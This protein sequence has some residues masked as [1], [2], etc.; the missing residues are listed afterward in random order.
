MNQFFLWHRFPYFSA[1]FFLFRFLIVSSH[2]SSLS[3]TASS[4]PDVYTFLS[5]PMLLLPDNPQMSLDL[6]LSW[7]PAQI[8]FRCFI[9]NSVSSFFL[10][11]SITVARVFCVSFA[12]YH[13]PFTD[14]SNPTVH[15]FLYRL[16]LLLPILLL[17]GL[18]SNTRLVV[19][20]SSILY[21]LPYHRSYPAWIRSS[22]G[23]KFC[24]IN[25]L[26]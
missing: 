11:F 1:E 23:L 12:S 19:L 2:V 18:A 7:P 17:V 20:S 10:L 14:S 3:I 8:F 6:I 24:C 26:V 5:H 21:R 9:P 4:N 25:C 16:M 13:V 22:T 15:A